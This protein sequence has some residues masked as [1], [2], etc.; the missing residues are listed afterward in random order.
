M[1][2]KAVFSF[3]ICSMV[4]PRFSFH[5]SYLRFLS[6]TYGVRLLP[7]LLKK[8]CRPGHYS[9]DVYIPKFHD[10]KLNA[11]RALQI[12]LCRVA[13]CHNALYTLHKSGVSTS[14]NY[15]NR[16]CFTI[17]LSCNRF[18]QYFDNAIAEIDIKTASYVWYQK[19]A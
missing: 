5:N 14:C 11:V 10:R 6:T 19:N 9:Q 16:G 13:K 7:R 18:Y 3:A 17:F 1:F 15:Y 8:Q 2:L 4:R 12:A